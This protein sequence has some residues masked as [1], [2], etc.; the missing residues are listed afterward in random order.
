[1]KMSIF[2]C[3]DG[4]VRIFALNFNRLLH[5]IPMTSSVSCIKL[6]KDWQ[7]LCGNHQGGLFIYD[8]RNYQKII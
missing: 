7:I 1:M 6:M 5:K 3:E 8:L 4:A 2:G